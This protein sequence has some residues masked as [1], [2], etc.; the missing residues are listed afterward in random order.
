MLNTMRLPFLLMVLF[1]MPVGLAKAEKTTVSWVILP[2]APGSVRADAAQTLGDLLAQKL[3]QTAGMAVVDRAQFDKVLAERKLDPHQTGPAIACDLMVRL[4]M[5]EDRQSSIRMDVID[6]SWGNVLRNEV[7]PNPAD[8]VSK[9]LA[10]LT[11]VCKK[12]AGTVRDGSERR[13]RIR[14]LVENPDAMPRLSPLANRLTNIFEAALDNC[15]NAVRVRHLEAFSAREESLLLLMGLSRLPG[16]RNFTPQADAILVVRL[17]EKDALQKSFDDTQIEISV[18]LTSPGKETPARSFLGKVRDWDKTVLAAWEGIAHD[19]GPESSAAGAKA[20]DQMILRRKQAE[21]EFQMA[22]SLQPTGNGEH[23]HAQK[24]ERLAAAVKIDPTFERAASELVV[25]LYYTVADSPHNEAW[26]RNRDEGLEAA[27]GYLRQFGVHS[28]RGRNVFFLVSALLNLD[29]NLPLRANVGEMLEDLIETALRDPQWKDYFKPIMTNLVFARYRL[30]SEPLEQKRIWLDDK[31]RRLDLWAD[32]YVREH[33]GGDT[34]SLHI[35]ER[36]INLARAEESPERAASLVRQAM[37]GMTRRGERLKKTDWTF[38]NVPLIV[39]ELHDAKLEDEFTKWTKQIAEQPLTFLTP[40]APQYRIYGRNLP[41]IVP[42]ERVREIPHGEVQPL[43]ATAD[44]LYV[45][46]NDGDRVVRYWSRTGGSLTDLPQPLTAYAGPHSSDSHGRKRLLLRSAAVVGGKLYLATEETGLQIYDP[47]ARCWA[48]LSVAH[49]LPHPSVNSVLPLGE[50]SL[51]CAAGLG[52]ASTGSIFKVSLP[53]HEITLLWRTEEQYQQ[54]WR[55]DGVWK[56]DNEWMALNHS[57]LFSDLTGNPRFTDW[58]H[59]PTRGYAI[60]DCDWGGTI[61]SFVTVESRRFVIRR[62]GLHELD[63]RGQAIRSWWL[64]DWCE[65]DCTHRWPLL[66]FSSDVPGDVGDEAVDPDDSLAVSTHS[67]RRKIIGCGSCFYLLGRFDPAGL[68][69]GVV[70]GDFRQFFTLIWCY[71]PKLDRW[72]GPLLAGKLVHD[73]VAD[74]DG[75]WLGRDDGLDFLKTAAFKAAASKAGLAMTSAEFLAAREKWARGLSPLDQARHAAATGRADLAIA[76]LKQLLS[77][78][79]NDPDA[80]VLL[81]ILN[82]PWAR[83]AHSTAESLDLYKRLAS[84]KDPSAQ[85]T[86]LYGQFV[87]LMA[88]LQSGGVQQDRNVTLD[89]AI[90]IGERILALVGAK[91]MRCA[92]NVR[93]DMKWLR[94]SFTHRAKPAPAAATR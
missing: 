36:A 73:V 88:A 41:P 13:T 87:V 56:V 29:T 85:L 66:P 47:V 81:A 33:P 20:M 3:V 1:I 2:P 26:K 8:D 63:Q 77:Q 79:P 38:G 72:Y 93:F 58:R 48:V 5:Q 16:R 9:T 43:A 94:W 31:L 25:A 80:L 19:L 75:L 71:D 22:K 45:I 40:T 82:E 24:V 35:W 57:S 42:T 60:N 65:F 83:G 46:V 68:F 15:A 55:L 64:R 76:G 7:V 90:E 6:L 34:Q 27:F 17:R 37:Q 4:T 18:Q 69:D 78:H 92:E 53:S 10:R 62:N 86:G 11:D 70:D 59:W 49:G 28:D 61:A 30:L 67:P 23:V 54:A 91:N 14:L 21:A 32:A 89:G 44:G 12:A 39:Q 50:D 74:A 84:L 51:L 52:N